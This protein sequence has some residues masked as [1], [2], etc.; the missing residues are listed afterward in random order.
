MNKTAK[1][2]VAAALALATT[3]TAQWTWELQSDGGQVPIGSSSF[4]EGG[5]YWFTYG[6]EKENGNDGVG[7]C[8]STNFPAG[9]EDEDVVSDAWRQLNEGSGVIYTFN[10]TCT[11]K[12]RFAGIGFNW[13]NGGSTKYKISEGGDP[14]GGASTIT[15]YYNLTTETGVSC[16]LEL[17]SDG[18]TAYDNYTV[19]LPAGNNSSGK[20]YPLTGGSGGFTQENWG[21]TITWAQAW[22]ASE[23]FKFKCSAGLGSE[24]G[25]KSAS[26]ILT[27]VQF[28]GGGSSPI[29]DNG[30]SAARHLN[31]AQNG[32]F[33]SLSVER[34]AFVQ[35]VNLQGA[36]VHT[37]TLSSANDK[38]NLSSLPTGIYM[39]RVPSL[40]YTNKLIL[41]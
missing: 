18:A 15:V 39:V 22:A 28:G 30:G 6:D 5:G 20:T 25:Q 40:N 4:P 17:S 38:M 27:K 7:G 23:G 21:T 29:L 35:V 31:M 32:R 13:F 14:T 9:S 37:Q 36:V 3:A 2:A 1:I 33:V 11:Y 8:S 34:S 26:L 24:V 41:K 12:Y 10:T 19:A 16:K